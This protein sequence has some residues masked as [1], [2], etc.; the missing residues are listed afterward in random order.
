M[1]YF[2]TIHD[3]T[4]KRLDDTSDCYMDNSDE[5]SA[6]LINAAADIVGLDDGE[7]AYRVG[8][9]FAGYQY[10]RIVEFQD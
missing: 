4:G 7:T 2:F 8:D 3:E 5:V 10:L 6:Y 1:R 9:D